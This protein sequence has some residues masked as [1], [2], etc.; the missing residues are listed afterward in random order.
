MS[1][2]ENL[3]IVRH[4]FDAWNAHDPNH[5]AKLFD[6]KYVEESD[7]LP[8]R[9]LGREAGLQVMRMYI[10]AF[11][12][13]HFVLDQMIAS[14][15]YV[16]ARWTATGTHRGDLMGIPATNRPAVTH[17]CSVLELRI[18]KLAHGWVYWDTGSL[19]RQLGV[20]PAR[21]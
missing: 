9:I 19:L 15:D 11:P 14:G 4:A 16:V 13:L 8:E 21:A 2:Q 5:L 7:T 6:E 17:G 10:R 1:E 12:D 20:L 3:Q 18:G